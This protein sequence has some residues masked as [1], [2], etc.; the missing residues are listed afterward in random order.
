MT[1][2]ENKGVKHEVNCLK[3]NSTECVCMTEKEIEECEKQIEN[4]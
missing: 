4:K 3:S 1:N 2:K